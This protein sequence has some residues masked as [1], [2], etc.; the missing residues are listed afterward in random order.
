M[1]CMAFFSQF[2][3][4]CINLYCH[5][6]LWYV[7]LV[8]AGNTTDNSNLSAPKI[9]RQKYFARVS[10]RLRNKRSVKQMTYVLYHRIGSAAH[11]LVAVTASKTFPLAYVEHN[12]R[13]QR[14]RSVIINSHT[15]MTLVWRSLAAVALGADTRILRSDAV[16]DVEEADDSAIADEIVDSEQIVTKIQK[17]KEKQE[18]Q[19]PIVVKCEPL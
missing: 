12:L 10:D 16:D 13:E 7:P 4:F 11:R 15:A 9:F 2:G 3:L 14:L 8:C 6:N 5:N 19:K 18:M 1:A 17:E